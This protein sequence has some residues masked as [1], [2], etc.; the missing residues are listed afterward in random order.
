MVPRTL[1]AQLALVLVLLLLAIGLTYAIVNS[2]VL[3][4]HLAT[5]DQTF[6][7]DL[8]RNLVA[9]RNLVREGRLDRQALKDTFHH[10]MEINP[11][12]EIY[13]VDL[14]GELMAYS[15]D[16]GKVVRDRVSLAPVHSFLSGEQ[17]YPLLGDDPRSFDRQK[18]FS[19]TPVPSSDEV[20]GYLY[21]VLRGELFD[22]VEDAFQ[23]SYYLRL[24]SWA[25][26]ISLVFGLIAGLIIFRIMTR[27]LRFLT[28]IVEE[29]R[30]SDFRNELTGHTRRHRRPRDEIDQL[31]K[32]FELMSHRIVG[33]IA[34]LREKDNARREL[35]AHVSHDLR[36]PLASLSGYIET[37]QIKGD[38][39]TLSERRRYL[40]IAAEH[41]SRLATLVDDLFELAKLEAADTPPQVEP[42]SLS[43]LVQDVV[44]KFGLE[45]ENQ[46]IQLEAE[47]PGAI[48]LATADI[49]LIERVLENIITNALDHTPGGGK[50]R[51][52]LGRV[53]EK[54]SVEISDTGSGIPEPDLPRIFER[55]YRAQ[56]RHR[57]GSHA[58]LGLA[59]AKRIL[60]LHHS[61]ISVRSEVKKGTTFSFDLPIWAG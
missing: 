20:E 4:R 53:E 5:I 34:E 23:D 42:F 40:D 15:A 46:N 49:G 12:I 3:Q 56:N 41:A 26:M 39:L 30:R 47:I 16:P 60:D 54:L 28:G 43:D 14:S 38:S 57:E 50:V 51:I 35:V 33:Q 58:G 22:R 9:E 61:R 36:T 8:A 45:A 27:R 29:F 24:G 55:F 6:N 13:L 17:N 1:Y 48:P 21:V 10:Y 59:I 31:Q 11:S 37:L 32:T 25:V 2:Y 18:I 52:R 44:Q 7:R 19:V